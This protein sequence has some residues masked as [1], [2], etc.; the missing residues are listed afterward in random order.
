MAHMN[1]E[2]TNECEPRR[3]CYNILRRS[4]LRVC[5]VALGIRFFRASSSD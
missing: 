3:W 2:Y 1:P 5:N 4:E